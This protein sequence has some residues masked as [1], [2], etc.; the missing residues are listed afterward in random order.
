MIIR[1]EWETVTRGEGTLD[2]PDGLEPGDVTSEAVRYARGWDSAED[3]TG[4]EITHVSWH[5]VD[6]KPGRA[7]SRRAGIGGV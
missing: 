2:L 5:T 3:D 7:G 1:V 4:R 6:E